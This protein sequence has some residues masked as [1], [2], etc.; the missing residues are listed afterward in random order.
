MGARENKW[1]KEHNISVTGFHT[2]FYT[3]GGG[4]GGGGEVTL[5]GDSKQMCAKQTNHALLGYAPQEYF[6]KN[7]CPEIESGGQHLCSKILLHVKILW[8]PFGGGGGG[9][10]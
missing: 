10:S 9:F 2:G 5:F 8:G 7:S 4:G 3:S 6:E 1:S